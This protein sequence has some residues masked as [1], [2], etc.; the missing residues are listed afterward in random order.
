MANNFVDRVATKPNRYKVTP[1]NGGEPYYAIL[2]R[3][4]EPVVEG[5]PLNA[6]T[7]NNLVLSGSY[8]EAT[9]E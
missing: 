1:E 3:A 6:E 9:L 8:V 4:D 7:L 2:E 5:T